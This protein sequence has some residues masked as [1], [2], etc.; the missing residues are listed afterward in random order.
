MRRYMASLG[1]FCKKIDQVCADLNVI[2]VVFIIGLAV[3]V[4][5]FW[6]CNMIQKDIRRARTTTQLEEIQTGKPDYRAIQVQY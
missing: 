2:L 4:T 3:L 1:K 6:L 5:T